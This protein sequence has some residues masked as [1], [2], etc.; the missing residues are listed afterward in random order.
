MKK[1]SEDFQVIKELYLQAYQEKLFTFVPKSEDGYDV[2]KD[3]AEKYALSL[4]PEVE[5]YLDEYKANPYPQ[6][7]A[8]LAADIYRGK[9]AICNKF[10]AMVGLPKARP[11]SKSNGKTNKNEDSIP[12]RY[13]Y[14]VEIY[15]TIPG[16]NVLSYFSGYSTSAFRQARH[17]VESKGFKFEREGDNWRVIERPNDKEIQEVKAQIEGAKK[18]ISEGKKLLTDGETALFDLQARLKDLVGK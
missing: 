9:G 14:W 16:D 4:V 8:T 12:K 11:D 2:A 13:Q 1:G 17:V 10:R 6:K 5:P 3:A 18:I 15:D 7:H